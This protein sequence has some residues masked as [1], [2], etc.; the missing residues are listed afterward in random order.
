[1]TCSHQPAAQRAESGSSRKG[2][3]QR[4]GLALA[5]P[6][7]S[8]GRTAGCQ[9]ARRGAA[10]RRQAAIICR[11]RGPWSRTTRAFSSCFT[12]NIHS[13]PLPFTHACLWSRLS[14]S[15]SP[16]DNCYKD[17]ACLAAVPRSSRRPTPTPTPTPPYHP[18]LDPERD[19]HLHRHSP[20]NSIHTPTP[21]APSSPPS[22]A[23]PAPRPSP[24]RNPQ[25]ACS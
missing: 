20:P 16:A 24:W 18:N 19:D 6:V 9:R 1:M 3:R 2:E 10:T 5:A 8:G 4:A 12:F 11:R 15:F 25:S 13:P 14:K 17:A 23:A 21:A 22:A 7:T